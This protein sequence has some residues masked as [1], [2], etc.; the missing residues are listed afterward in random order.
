MGQVEPSSEI[1]GQVE[2]S[3]VTMG[4]T[5]DRERLVLRHGPGTVQCCDH[6]LHRV[7]VEVSTETKGQV[8]PSSEIVGQVETRTGTMGYTEDRERLV[9]RPVA[10]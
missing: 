3:T 9:L 8:E 10:R 5:E 7:Q 4:Y 1:M 6:G 2:N